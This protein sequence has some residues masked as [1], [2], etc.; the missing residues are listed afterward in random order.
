MIV[1]CAGAVFVVATGV[2][3]AATLYTGSTSQDEAVALKSSGGAVTLFKLLLTEHCRNPSGG[4]TGS[5][6]G[7]YTHRG[8][9]GLNRFGHFFHRVAKRRLLTAQK[10]Q[11]FNVTI[12]FE[13]T[14]RGR[15]ASG[16]FKGVFRFF[17]LSGRYVGSCTTGTVSWS[18]HSG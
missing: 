15:H 5:T 11:R 18:A 4:S 14:V 16:T 10:N 2:A 17:T 6:A 1:V 7:H 8:R 12:S 9:L 3:L 13:G